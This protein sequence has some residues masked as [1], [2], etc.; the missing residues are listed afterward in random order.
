ILIFGKINKLLPSIYCIFLRIRVV[1][2]NKV[3]YYF[4]K[5]FGNEANNRYDTIAVIGLFYVSMKKSA[6]PLK[7]NLG[8]M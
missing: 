3:C 4:F 7:H 2:L 6:V 8:D 5:L 1:F